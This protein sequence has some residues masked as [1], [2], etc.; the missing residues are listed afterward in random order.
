MNVWY[1]ISAVGSLIAIYF[2]YKALR[3]IIKG[4]I[5]YRKLGK[6]EFIK[7]LQKGFDGITPTQRV[8]GEL[9]GVYITL[10]GMVT[11]LVVVPIVRLTGIWYWAELLLLGGLVMTVWQLIGK[12]Q[13]YR[14]LKK[15]DEIMKELEEQNANN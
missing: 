12:L 10:L 3:R 2:L 7:R 5:S 9:N 4:I 8:K 14:I 1:Y 11:G 6:E 13:Q 15:Q